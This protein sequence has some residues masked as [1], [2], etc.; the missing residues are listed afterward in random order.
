MTNRVLRGITTALVLTAATAAHARAQR[1]STPADMKAM[2]EHMQVTK[3][4]PKNSA[5]SMRAAGLVTQL[6][7]SIAKYKDVN[8]AVADGFRQF[9]P[10]VKDQP[11][12]HFTNYRWACTPDHNQPQ[13]TL[14]PFTLRISPVM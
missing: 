12:Y 14:P 6:R 4:G 10:Q 3:L 8:L 11:V 5:D 1:V 9:A 7:S 2:Q 13:R